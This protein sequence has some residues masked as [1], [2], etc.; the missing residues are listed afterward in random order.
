MSNKPVNDQQSR[1]QFLK[2]TGMVVGA[3]GGM[4][5]SQPAQ[6]VPTP[7]PVPQKWDT[8]VDVLIIGTGFA[9]LAAAIEARNAQAEV[10]IID[11][12]PLLGGN[13][14]LNGGDLAAAGSKMQKEAGI[15]DSPELMYQDM[16]KAGNGLNYPELARTVA[17]HSVEALEWAQSIGAQFNVVNYHGGHSVKRAHQLVQRSGS[18][19]IVKQQQKAKE[20]GAVIEQRAKLLRL[21]VEPDGRVI[22]AEIRRGYRFPDENSGE[23]VYIRARKG[24]VLASGG[25]SQGVALRQMYDPRLTESFTSTNHPGATGEAIMAACM[26]GALDTQMDWIQLGPWT[27]PDE[28]G[29]GYVPQFVERVVGYGLMVDPATG[30]RFFKETGN[31]KERADAIIQLGHPAI[32]IADKTNTDNM[33]DPGQREGALKNGSLKP[34]NTLEELAKAYE[35]PVDA[36]VAQVKR[37]N[38][39]VSQRNDADLDCM[40]FQDAVPNVTPPFYAARLWPRVHHTMGGLAINKDAQVIGFDLKP[41]PGLYAAGETVGGVH[42]AVRLGSVAMTDCIVF[43][44]IAG[45]NAALTV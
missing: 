33:V 3:L 1:R 43:G 7:S 9:G 4:A 27:S 15:D 39:F 35:M 16:L 45:K 12:M 30:K 11:K 8:T 32:I 24:V 26:I 14:V 23:I 34:Y 18:G 25:F 42:G 22:G 6:A 21:I 40:I 17:E 29:F 19:L 38:E 36:F 5:L 28:K 10:L 31:R 2:S 20:L 41:I 13:S 44:R 37:W